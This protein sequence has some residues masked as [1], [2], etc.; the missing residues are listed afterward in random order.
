[1]KLFV[2]SAL[3]ALAAAKESRNLR[4]EGIHD[5]LDE[6]NPDKPRKIC[7]LA[8]DDANA[9]ADADALL[10]SL[11]LGD[12][13]GC[14][15]CPRNNG[16]EKCVA[17]EPNETCDKEEEKEEEKTEVSTVMNENAVAE[18]EEDEEE[19]DGKK[20]RK[21]CKKAGTSADACATASDVIASMALENTAGCLMCPW[22]QDMERCVAVGY[23]GSCP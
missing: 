16:S 8:R 18:K 3:L 1:M 7:K 11:G 17:L 19:L 5:K 2:A 10:A 12:E 15:M 20:S 23:D 6:P 13:V 9:C 4:Q 21:I 14:T 22:K